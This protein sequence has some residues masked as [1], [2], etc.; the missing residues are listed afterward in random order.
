[1]NGNEAQET[2]EEWCEEHGGSHTDFSHIGKDRSTC[3]LG[4]ATIK[5]DTQGGDVRTEAT[6]ERNGTEA[7]YHGDLD[8]VVWDRSKD[9]IR[10]A[11]T[12]SGDLGIGLMIGD[13]GKER[14]P[15]Y[16][17]PP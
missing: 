5:I 4:D 6:L 14:D 9:Q 13:P 10:F 15:I 16:N 3:D 2:F 8:R 7:T 11:K 12:G 1:M 17:I